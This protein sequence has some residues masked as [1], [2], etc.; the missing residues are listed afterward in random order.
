MTIEYKGMIYGVP[1]HSNMDMPWAGKDADI[2][3]DTP[4]RAMFYKFMGAVGH[5]TRDVITEYRFRYHT[6]PVRVVYDVAADTINA[7]GGIRDS[8]HVGW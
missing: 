5:R 3:K 8:L 6:A 4:E 2:S 7:I 1:F